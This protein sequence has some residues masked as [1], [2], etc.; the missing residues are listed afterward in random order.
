MSCVKQSIFV[1]T[2]WVSLAV[3]AAPQDSPPVILQNS[4]VCRGVIT[5]IKG[6]I[7]PP[8][9][10]YSPQ[11]KYPKNERK[12][13]HQ[14]TVKLSVVVGLYGDPLDVAVLQTLSP[15]FDESAM[16]AVKLWKFKPAVK[17]G[18]PVQVK[19]AVEVAFHLYDSSGNVIP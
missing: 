10:T 14:G 12:A 3:V 5:D 11:P 1:M 7:T 19:I 2:L 17:Y 18:K 15:D 8:S 13:H 16:E 6:C 4:G 9:P